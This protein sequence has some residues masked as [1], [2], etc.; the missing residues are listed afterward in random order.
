LANA[1]ARLVVSTALCISVL[2]AAAKLFAVFQSSTSALLATTVHSLIDTSCLGLLILGLSKA[3]AA[4]L[5]P[6]G[7]TQDRAIYFWSFIVA[8]VL[9]SMG[10]GIA[11]YEGVERLARPQPLLSTAS[12]LPTLLLAAVGGVIITSMA[13][14]H[15]RTSNISI[16]PLE[17]G[18]PRPDIAPTTAVLVI[19]VACVAGNLLALGGLLGSANGG[20]QRSDPFAAIAVGLAMSAV[21]AFMAIEVKRLLVAA[22]H[23]D[24][25]RLP[26]SASVRAPV[27]DTSSWDVEVRSPYE[28]R[29]MPIG[30]PAVIAMASASPPPPSEALVEVKI[31][32]AIE[33]PR[34][35]VASS[36]A[37]SPAQKPTVTVRQ[38]GRKGRGKRRR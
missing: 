36:P 31:A 8:I 32:A 30:G 37:S 6:A 11:L 1:G 10:G 25:A 22:S 26:A 12:V 14:R 33:E 17:V 21:A 35:T 27:E 2:T 3:S 38:A 13:L 20:D 18:V 19:A 16:H 4:P 9:Y 23:A 24:D 28:T 29:S 34:Q 15:L 5:F 7:R